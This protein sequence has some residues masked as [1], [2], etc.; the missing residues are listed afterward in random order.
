VAEANGP[1]HARVKTPTVLQMEAVE[2]GAAALAMVL[3][4]FGRIVPLAV[5][6]RECGVSRDG[7]KASNV[8]KAARNYGLLAKGFKKPL[9]GLYEIPYPAILFW[10]F[11]HFV[12]LEGFQGDDAW[13][14]DPES[15][16]RKVGLQE[17]DESFTGVVIVLERGADFR[18][19][20]KRRSVVAA[21]ARDLRGSHESIAFLFLAGFL[22]VVPHI[23]SPALFQVFID[24]VLVRGRESWL[25]PLIAGMAGVTLV[26]L[27]LQWLQ[28]KHLREL[29]IKLATKLSSRFLHHVL[30]LPIEYFGQRFSGELS[31]RMQ[32]NDKVA[33]I[34]SGQVARAGIDAIMLVFYAV[35]MLAYSPILTLI[36]VT[37]SILDIACF[38]L[39]M[40]AQLVATLKVQQEHGKLEGATI[41]GLQ[42]IETLKATGQEASFFTRWAGAEARVANANQ[43]M[44]LSHALLAGLPGVLAAV[45]TFLVFV[46]GGFRVMHGQLTVGMLVAFQ[47][48][49]AGFQS[50]VSTLLHL[51]ATLQETGVD[52]ERLDD[53]L[54]HPPDPIAAERERLS[55]EIRSDAPARLEGTV[56]L[57][58]VTFGFSRV[59][60]PLISGFS[61]KVAPGQRV[62]LVGASGS[63]KST[64]AKLVTGIHRP[65][66]G[67]VRID[68]RRLAEIPKHVIACSLGMVDQD[69]FFFA[70]TVCENLTLWDP[71]VPDSAL[72]R[73]LQD[74]AVLDVVKGL[75]GGLNAQ[76]LEGGKN[77]SGGQRQRLEI[78]RALVNDPSILVLDEATSALDA[79]TEFII[80]Q[81]LRRRGCTCII[82]A[83][84]LSTVKTCDEIVVLKQGVVVERGNHDELWAAGGEYARLV[85]SERQDK[86]VSAPGAMAGA[87][88]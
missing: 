72:E 43:E 70:G 59:A 57:T 65:D 2:C 13:I 16:R 5:L 86:Q 87:A 35:F 8:A 80:G 66:E 26:E 44:V 27:A 29:R 63:G 64:I 1:L 88:S 51:S 21:L 36:A 85:A 47:G 39:L 68:G 37:F 77:L 84:R 20:G 60:P 31:S 46:V 3:A 78:A 7:S 79:E 25:I 82:V 62:A 53:V 69:L 28:A 12:V 10:N 33:A 22:L 42:S 45:S 48:L 34:L 75:P 23:A 56:E 50:P 73:A 76:L 32:L 54:A 81:N 74:A 83:H 11:N 41:A 9:S 61:L 14:N 40:R 24:H 67:E 6:R 49:M 17:L 4:Y 58:E 15:G 55:K 71:T 52:L 19:E 38:R 30:R 18:A